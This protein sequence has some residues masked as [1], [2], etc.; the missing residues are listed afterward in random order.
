VRAVLIDHIGESPRVTEVPEPEC[1]PDGV[2]VEVRA[3]GVCRSDWHAWMGHEEI[4]LPHVPGHEFAG[5]VVEVGAQV[6]G[7][8][9]GDR[10]TA[11]FVYACG[12]CAQCRAGDHQI[13]DR[14]EQPGF[15]RWGSF[16]ERVVVTRAGT[17]LVRLPDGLDFATAATLGCRFATAYRAV[18]TQG[19]LVAGETLVVVGC[20]GVGLSAIQIGLSLGARVVGVDPYAGARAAA[21]QLGARSA[22]SVAEAVAPFGPAHVAMDA[23]GSAES[24]ETAYA[25][26]G[27]RGRH[28]QVGLLVGDAAFPR[29]DLAR[30]IAEELEIRGSHGMPAHAYPEMLDRIVAGDLD[31]GRTI[32]RRIGLDELPAA[33][34][35]MSEPPV[36]AGVTVAE[37]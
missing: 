32:G 30:A 11:P 34:V 37:L 4:A 15:T 20:G 7:W 6:S 33:L 36:A 16:A 25:A 27:K 17:N 28:L 21:E 31:P 18:V 35:A 13:C 3:T 1:P 2:V 12:A 8:T 14:Q 24:A 22:A 23:F 10:V 5:V 9:L 19:R 29:L 26:L